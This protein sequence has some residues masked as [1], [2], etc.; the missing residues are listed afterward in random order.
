[1]TPRLAEIIAAM[2]AAKLDAEASGSVA[3]RGRIART[4]YREPNV[5]SRATSSRTEGRR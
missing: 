5:G 4:R 1:M 3:A 2:V